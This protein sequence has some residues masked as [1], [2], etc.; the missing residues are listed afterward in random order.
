V[1]IQ[2]I[3]NATLI[4]RVATQ[5]ILVDPMLGPKGS[6]M[7]FAF[8]R[9]R[10]RRNPTAPLPD[11]AQVALEDL[12]AGLITHCRRWHYD[13]LDLAGT[14]LLAR[15]QIPVYCSYLDQAYLR[16]R[17][18]VTVPLRPNQQQEFL[19]GSISPLETQHG[20][21]LIGRLMG[22]GLGYLI[23][24]PNEP[25]LYISGDTVL[26][27]VVRKVLTE[28]QPDIA[29]LAVGSASLDLGRPILMPLSE[30]LTFVRLAPGRVIATRMEA[31]NHCPVTRS[32]FREA[33]AKA[34]LSDKIHIPVDGEIINV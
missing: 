8:F 19:G 27:P 34:G 21:G 22:P 11:N 5:S 6:L 30:M 26:T 29:V 16:K 14:R 28:L 1:Q 15:Q 33:L 3:R 7:P 13:H 10:P 20:Y 9:H 24:L 17:G 32:Q 4:I 25:S 31:V 2:F 18:I 23:D 12:T